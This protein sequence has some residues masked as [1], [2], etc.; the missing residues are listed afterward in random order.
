MELESEQSNQLAPTSSPNLPTDVSIDADPEHAPKSAAKLTSSTEPED[1]DED[2]EFA[3]LPPREALLRLHVCTVR[4]SARLIEFSRSQMDATPDQ[5]S[6]AE[7]QSRAARQYLDG[8]CTEADQLSIEAKQQATATVTARA[9]ESTDA[10]DR[11]LALAF[12]YEPLNDVSAATA[13]QIFIA[14]L[15]SG[16]PELLAW[17]GGSLNTREG[18]TVERLGPYAASD[19]SFASFVLAGCDLG[20]DC[21]PNSLWF[22]FNCADSAAACMYDNLEAQLLSRSYPPRAHPY[23]Q[24]ERRNIVLRIRSG[25]G[26]SLFAPVRPP[27]S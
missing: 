13:R 19:L 5:I 24:R 8:L 9:L 25:Q 20:A 16:D 12:N 15:S 11:L 22:Q 2:E 6:P 18:S 21:S 27:K 7:Q 1:E 4:A 17:I 10:A 14:A 3:H 26:A 23:I